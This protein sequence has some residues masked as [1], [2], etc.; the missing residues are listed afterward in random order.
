MA[1]A[2]PWRIFTPQLMPC[3]KIFLALCVEKKSSGHFF[4]PVPNVIFSAKITMKERKKK[5][6]ARFSF[7]Q[8]IV[9]NCKQF[10]TD[11]QTYKRK[12]ISFF[13]KDKTLRLLLW[14]PLEGPYRFW[15]QF[16]LVYVRSS[17]VSCSKTCVT[18]SFL[19]KEAINSTPKK[20]HA[21]LKIFQKIL[22]I[23]EI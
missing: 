18:S 23:D 17:R 21:W 20:N 15:M 19:A 22:F 2:C 7:V 1:A 9:L 14:D 5:I 16:G 6:L 13:L 10:K 8:K 3:G 12:M 11:S 4:R